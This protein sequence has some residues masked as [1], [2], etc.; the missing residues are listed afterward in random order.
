MHEQPDPEHQRPV[1]VSDGTVT[2]LADRVETDLIG[3]NV[4]AGRWTFQIVEDFDDG[5]VL[6]PVPGPDP[7][8]PRTALWCE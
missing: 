3:R 7:R 6:H 4:S 1:G 5:R 2:A 8:P